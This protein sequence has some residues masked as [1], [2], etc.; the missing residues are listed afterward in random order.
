MT[1]ADTRRILEQ[2]ARQLARRTDTGRHSEFGVDMLTFALGRERFAVESRFVFAAFPLVELV[3]LPG[4]TPPVVGLTRWRGD[5]LTVADIRRL[6]GLTAG[7]LDDL[8]RVIVIGDASP[9]IGILADTLSDI[10]SIDP[11]QLHPPTKVRADHAPTLL[12][13]VTSD[14]I[15][16][17]DVAALLARQADTAPL[18]DTPT[19]PSANSNS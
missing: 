6:V 4:A 1:D 13:G 19:L 11:T 18:A 8:A 17:I 14:A 7:A 10:V 16:I 15:S 5:V 2:R 12:R 3:P 9:E